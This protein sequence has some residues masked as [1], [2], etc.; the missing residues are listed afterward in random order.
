[1]TIN[2]FDKHIQLN[3][4]GTTLYLSLFVLIILTV[5]IVDMR[6]VMKK[7]WLCPQ[8]SKPFYPKWHQS[9]LT[10]HLGKAHLLRC[11][12]CHEKSFCTE[13]KYGDYH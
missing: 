9:L 6:S 4:T 5:I 12:H 13:A 8:C 7:R 2:W 1:M 10:I 11:P 3:A